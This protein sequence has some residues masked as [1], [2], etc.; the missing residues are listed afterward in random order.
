MNNFDI[1]RGDI[2][3]IYKYPNQFG[4]E[5]E[6][7]RPAIVVS[8]DQ[9][10]RSSEV[11][12][13]VY[14]TTQPKTDLPTHVRILSTRKESTALCEQI[15]S[16]DKSRIGDFIGSCNT[17]EMNAINVALMI[18]VDLKFENTGENEKTVAKKEPVQSPSDELMKVEIQRDTYKQLYEE[19]LKRLIDK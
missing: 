4:S 14:C 15:T 9:C 16:V 11:I 5:Q 3:Y 13:V 2:F 18:S 1:K 17:Q 19:L 10:N 12:E 7:G 6:S 8:N